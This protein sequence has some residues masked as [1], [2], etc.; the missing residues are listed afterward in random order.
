MQGDTAVKMDIDIVALCDASRYTQAEFIY[1][2]LT[3]AK[4]VILKFLPR[5]NEYGFIHDI[6]NNAITIEAISYASDKNEIMQF[7]I[8]QIYS[9]IFITNYLHANQGRVTQNLADYLENTLSPAYHV[10]IQ[11]SR[12]QKADQEYLYQ[13][14]TFCNIPYVVKYGYNPYKITVDKDFA[15]S[16]M[17]NRN[18]EIENIMLHQMTLGHL[19][20]YQSMNADEL[21]REISN[22]TWLPF[23]CERIFELECCFKFIEKYEQL[24]LIIAKR[25]M[26]YSA[27][28]PAHPLKQILQNWPPN[29]KE[30]REEFVWAVK[31]KV[32]INE[33]MYDVCPQ[34][35][36]TE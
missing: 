24:P 18:S 31:C 7:I 2:H 27:C 1:K 10:K 16:V 23:T 30:Q 17:K 29:N 20:S 28:I 33:I 34:T 19:R 26:E 5:D 12:Q 3:H 36:A 11:E 22:E 6:F 4:N 13:V 8:T 15:L 14:T 9:E 32:L 25:W 21:Q 35:T